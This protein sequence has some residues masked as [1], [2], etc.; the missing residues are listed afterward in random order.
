[1][2]DNSVYGLIHV[3]Y[4]EKLKENEPNRICFLID[5]GTDSKKSFDI[6]TK[7]F[8]HRLKHREMVGCHIYNSINNSTYNWQYQKNYILDQ[9]L[10]SF[11]RLIKY[12]NLLYRKGRQFSRETFQICLV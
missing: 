5:G 12:P 8:L 11:D 9:Y 2:S 1:M 6:I 3:K 7:E 10:F 4:I